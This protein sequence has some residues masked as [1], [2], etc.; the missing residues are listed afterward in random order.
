LPLALNFHIVPM[1]RSRQVRLPGTACRAPTENT[2]CVA[3]AA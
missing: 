1:A 3:D 2:L